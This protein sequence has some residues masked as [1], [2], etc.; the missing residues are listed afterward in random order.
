MEDTPTWEED[1]VIHRRN[2]RLGHEI[3]LIPMESVH[4]KNGSVW[5]IPISLDSL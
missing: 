2:R 5:L 3:N 4:N 1:Q